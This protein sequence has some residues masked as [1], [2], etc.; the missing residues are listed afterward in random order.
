MRWKQANNKKKHDKPMKDGSAKRK[1]KESKKEN[2]LNE[3]ASSS[4]A[5]PRCKPSSSV[6]QA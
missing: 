5:D 4:K 2:T 1:W 6:P 3:E